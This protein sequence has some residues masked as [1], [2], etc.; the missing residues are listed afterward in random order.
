MERGNHRRQNEKRIRSNKELCL[1]CHIRKAQKKKD[2][3]RYKD[4]QNV[5]KNL[6]LLVLCDV[7]LLQENV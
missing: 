6:T 2:E 7:T 4:K 5:Y 1:V 3:E